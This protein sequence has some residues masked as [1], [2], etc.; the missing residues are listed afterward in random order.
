MG[1]DKIILKTDEEIELIRQN[2]L[3]VSDTLT[4]VASMLCPGITGNELDMAAEEYIRDQQA[5]PGFKGLYGCPSTLLISKNEVVVHGLPDDVPFK[6]GDI[7]S[8]DC[9]VR[10]NGFYGDAAYTFVVGE[11]PE[12]TMRL[13]VVTKESLRL[14]I[15][16]AQKDARIGDVSHAIQHY[17]EKE[18][19]YSVV[20]KLV[21]HGVGR[22]L[23]EKPEVPNFGNRGRGVKIKEGLVIA[24]EPMINLGRKEVVQA[25]D[26]WTIY[27][28]DRKPSAHFEHTI[29]V[30]SDG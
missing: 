25:K 6:E 1:K 29:A 16:A 13:L 3:M 11:I 7:A 18:H 24:I 4:L 12:A 8:I 21:G 27:T 5:E 28:V 20:R 10:M 30:R 2:C 14:G 9:G 17:T 19:G 15:Q 23:H 26:G 22:D